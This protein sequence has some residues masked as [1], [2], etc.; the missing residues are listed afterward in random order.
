MTEIKRW[1]TEALEILLLVVAMLT[2]LQ[3]LFGRDVT[4]LFGMDVV[5]NIGDLASKF[6]NAGLVGILAISVVAWI[7]LKAR[8]FDRG[9]R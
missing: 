5:Q 3:I 9:G 2:V 1:L 6:G 7:V 4:R 8:P